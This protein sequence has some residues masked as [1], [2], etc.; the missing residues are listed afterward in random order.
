MIKKLRYSAKIRG[1]GRIAKKFH[2]ERERD[3]DRNSLKEVKKEY[4]SREKPRPLG[5]IG[6]E[7]LRDTNER[8]T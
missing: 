4:G 5:S 8:M 1:K 2:R 6:Q 7:D 3:R